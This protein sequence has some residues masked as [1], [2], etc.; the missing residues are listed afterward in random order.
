MVFSV[1]LAHDRIIVATIARRT[2]I[3]NSIPK[4]NLI[5]NFIIAKTAL[6][7]I[8]CYCSVAMLDFNCITITIRI[9]LYNPVQF[10]ELFKR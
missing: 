1:P 8:D 4:M 2:N 3:T 6:M 9:N 10:V 5:P 7:R